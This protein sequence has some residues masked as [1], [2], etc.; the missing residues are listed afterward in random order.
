MKK[1]ARAKR[2]AEEE[3]RYEQELKEAEK[4][5]NSVKA[6]QQ[7]EDEIEKR[8]LREKRRLRNTKPVSP[9]PFRPSSNT[10]PFG[11]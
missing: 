10:V 7:W 6:Y 8:K 4:E 9:Y 11:R 5:E 3:L 1:E 2:Q